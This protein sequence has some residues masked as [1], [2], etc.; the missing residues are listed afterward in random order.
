M[1]AILPPPPELPQPPAGRLCWHVIGINFALRQLADLCFM[2]SA[3]PTLHF[4][5][6]II[7]C[8]FA[9]GTDC[10]VPVMSGL[11]MRFMPAG[12]AHLTS[13]SSITIDVSIH[14][15]LSLNSLRM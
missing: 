9:F 4:D 2:L 15:Q 5:C 8:D 11:A 3:I 1:F 10:A 6:E 7:G 12:A 13:S 14:L